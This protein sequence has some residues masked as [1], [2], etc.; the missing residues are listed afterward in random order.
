MLSRFSFFIAGV[1]RPLWFWSLALG[2]SVGLGF[3]SKYVMALFVL[4]LLPLV[5]LSKQVRNPFFH[6]FP[7]IVLGSRYGDSARVV[8]EHSR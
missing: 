1:K 2:V 3:S 6:Q 5:V 7:W 8:V 4:S